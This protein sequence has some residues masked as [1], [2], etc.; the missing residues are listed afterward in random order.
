MGILLTWCPKCEVY[1]SPRL[2]ACWCCGEEPKMVEVP[3][4]HLPRSAGMT[5]EELIG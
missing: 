4:E 3:P 5:L 1:G 2:R